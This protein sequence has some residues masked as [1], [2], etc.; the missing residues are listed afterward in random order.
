ML[1][2]QWCCAADITVATGALQRFVLRG[3]VDDLEWALS[4]MQVLASLFQ[5]R[6]CEM[7]LGVLSTRPRD[8]FPGSTFKL[9]DVQ[10]AARMVGLVMKEHHLDYAKKACINQ[11][12]SL[13]DFMRT[14]KRA[15]EPSPSAGPIEE[16]PPRDH[17]SFSS[18]PTRQRA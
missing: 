7:I 13:E 9:A 4:S 15:F 11:C 3:S 10:A 14:L 18:A 8:L 2:L 5:L 6:M 16:P 17:A 1:N 12:G